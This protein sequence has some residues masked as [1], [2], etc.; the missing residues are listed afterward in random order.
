MTTNAI[1]QSASD[2]AFAKITTLAF[3]I[4]DLKR[5][6]KSGDIG[7]ITIEEMELLVN[8]TEKEL[9]IW[10]YIAKLIETDE[11]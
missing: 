1:H 4:Q 2:K 11:E 10:N 7:P 3:E 6:L 9:K 8:G 5:D